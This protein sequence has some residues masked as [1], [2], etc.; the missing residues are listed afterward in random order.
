MQAGIEIKQPAAKKPKQPKSALAIFKAQK[1]ENDKEFAASCDGKEA[2]EITKL[3]T[4]LFKAL[5]ED[6]RKVR[7][8]RSTPPPARAREAHSGVDLLL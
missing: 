8:V 3:A 1:L 7:Y 4:T 6:D 5:S 2:K